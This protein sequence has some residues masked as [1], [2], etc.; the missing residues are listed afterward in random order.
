MARVKLGDVAKEYKETIKSK[1]NLPIVGLEHLTPSEIKLTEWSEESDNTFSKGFKKGQMLFGRRRAYLKKA[2]LAPFDG[3]CSGDITVIEAIQGKIRED[4]LPFIIQNDDFFDYAVSRSAG[5]LSPRVKWEDLKNFE[6]ELPDYE[7]QS[8]LSELLS[9]A[10][11][12]KE[13]YQNLLKY[14][15][16]FVKSQF[17]EMF[18]DF[19]NNTKNWSIASFADIA[20]IDGNMTTDY[21]KY[22]DYPHIGI[23]SIEKDTGALSGYR[24]VKEDNVISGKYLFTPKHI[25]YSKIRPNLN[26]VALPDFDGLCSADAYPILPNEKNCNRVFLAYTM[27]SKFF[28]DYILQFCMR[29]N[30]P[31]V[32]RK[33]VSGFKTPLPPLELQNQFADFVQQVDKSKFVLKK[34]I[35]DID[36]VIKS[37]IQQD[38]S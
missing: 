22:A 12:L 3:I 5:S 36:K 38:L 28:L 37:L 4:L 10:Y 18:G 8:K 25:I 30:M 17:V 26:K 27:R 29:T 7:K 21:E 32:N 35:E 14:S 1:N 6:F 23:D 9:S 34:S 31:K 13:K 2:A 15:D 11:N 16:E 24:T 20:T 19:K 33:E